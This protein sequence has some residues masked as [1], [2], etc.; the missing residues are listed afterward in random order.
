MATTTTNILT[1]SSGFLTPI[2][3]IIALYIAYQQYRTNKDKLR[4]SLYDRRME[5]YRSLMDSLEFIMQNAEITNVE[6][7]KFAIAIDKGFFLF[8]MD[9][10]NYL[11]NIRD[12]YFSLQ[13][14]CRKLYH[15]PDVGIGVERNELAS[16]KRE[17]LLWFEDQR[18]EGAQQL[19]KKYLKIAA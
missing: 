2:V 10:N 16:K 15:D 1:I 9:I 4:W 14:F 6:L 17:L 11:N 3:A 5:V 7:S 13:E 18:R 8:D 19:F 12:K